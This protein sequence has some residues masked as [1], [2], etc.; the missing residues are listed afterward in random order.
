MATMVGLFS[1][2]GEHMPIFRHEKMIEATPESWVMINHL[3]FNQLTIQIFN[4]SIQVNKLHYRITCML[5]LVAVLLVTCTEWI[6]G[7]TIH[8]AWYQNLLLLFYSFVS[9]PVSSTPWSVSE[10]VIRCLKWIFLAT[11]YMHNCY[12]FATICVKHQMS[13]SLFPVPNISYR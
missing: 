1:S 11:T 12:S 6:S 7:A 4:Q 8:S 9:V 13:V 5:L 3:H 10:S 2:I